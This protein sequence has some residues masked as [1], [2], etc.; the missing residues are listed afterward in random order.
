M[1]SQE[2]AGFLFD[3]DGKDRV[4]GGGRVGP[5]DQVSLLAVPYPS[6]TQAASATG[7]V[8]PEIDGISAP[9]AEARKA[10]AAEV[11]IAAAV[12]AV[13]DAIGPAAE[14][15]PS[16]DSWL[17]LAGISA[18]AA[19]AL[20]AGAQSADEILFIDGSIKGYELLIAGARP[21]VHVIVLDPTLD[22]FEQITAA[23]AGREDVAAIHL[24]SHG[25]PGRVALGNTA[26]TVQSLAQHGAQLAAWSESLSPGADFLIYGCDVGQAIQGETLLNALSA[27]TGADTAASSNLTGSGPLGSDWNLEVSHGTIT[28]LLFADPAVLAGFTS[29]LAKPVVDLNGPAILNLADNFSTNSYTGG[30]SNLATIWTSGWFEFDG[31]PTRAFNPGGSTNSDNSPVSGNVVIPNVASGGTVGGLGTGQEIAFVGHA[32][33]YGDS[34]E[35]EVN[36]KA[37]TSAILSFSYRTAGL[38]AGDV[39]EVDVSNNAGASFVTVGTL[40][41]VTTNTTATFDI[42]SYISDTTTIRFAVSSGFAAASS[43]RFYFDNVSITADGNN[44]VTNY[45]EQAATPVS[46]TGGAAVITDTDTGQLLRSATVTLA[47]LQPGDTFAVG[48][49]P[50]GIVADTGTPGT[51]ILSSATGDTAAHFMTALGAITF[52]NGSNIPDTTLRSINITVTDAGNETSLS[53]TAFVR[54]LPYDNP[55][56][57]VAH[58][59]AASSLGTTAG[60]LFDG[61]SLATQR[62]VSTTLDY[63]QDT[64]GLSAALLT[65][66]AKGAAVINPDGSYSYT[67]NAGATGADSFSYTLISQA[68]V[69]GTNYQYWN[70][71]TITSL[72]TG[73]PTSAPDKSSFIV[74]YDVD[75]VALD[76]VGGTATANTSLDNFVVRF[77]NTLTI[78]TGGS[79]TFTTGS[80]DG[81]MVYIDTAGNGTY[82]TVVDNDGLHSYLS[83]SGSIT[84]APGTYTVRVDFMERGGQEDLRVYYA[85]ADTGG[86]L[87]NL[88]DVGQVLANSTTVGTVDVDIQ[89]GGPQLAL[90]T[91]VYAL[92]NFSTQAYTNNDGT[93][94]FAG[95]WIEQIDGG[96]P[97]SGG[98]RVTGGALRVSDTSSGGSTRSIWRDFEI[99]APG[100]NASKFGYQLSFDYNTPGTSTPGVHVQISTDGGA[101]Y[102][103]LDTISANGSTGTTHKTYDISSYAGGNVRIQF[104]PASPSSTERIN[105]DNVQIDAH[106][107]NYAAGTYIENATP[108]VAIAST[109][110]IVFG[111]TVTNV[112]GATVTIANAQAGDT[113]SYDNFVAG[114]SAALNGNTLTLSGTA[115]R[116]DYATALQHVFFSSGSEDPSTAGRTINVAVTD[117][118]TLVSNTATATL[119]VTAVNDAP[120]GIDGSVSTAQNVN[121]VL[122]TTDFAYA[123]AEGNSLSALRIAT[124]PAPALGTLEYDTTGGG[125]WTTVTAN[126][127]ITAANIAAGRLRYNPATTATGNATFAFQVLDNGGTANGGVD[128]DPVANNF[129][130]NVLPGVNSR[131]MLSGNLALISSQ[132]DSTSPTPQTLSQLAAGIFADS[133]PGAYMTGLAIVGNSA[134]AGTQGAWQYSVDGATWSAVGTVGNTAGTALAL[135]A[136]TLVRFVAVADYNGVPTA[137]SV[138]A[139]DDTYGGNF[140]TSATRV[141]VGTTP[142]ASTAISSAQYSLGTAVS[143]VNDAPLLTAA[144]PTL[145][146]ISASQP[147]AGPAGQLISAF[148]GSGANHSV[149]TDVDASPL[150]GIAVIGAGGAG[151]SWQYSTDGG[152]TWNAVGAVSVN[153]GLLLDTANMIRFNPDGNS[154]GSGVLSYRA[155]DETSGSVGAKLDTSTFGGSSAFSI[156][157]DSASITVTAP[158]GPILSGASAPLSYIEQAA[159]GAIDSAI[160]VADGR[161]ANLTGATVSI[162]NYVSGQDTLSFA[163]QNGITGSWNAGTGTLTLTGT[164]TLANYQTALRSITYSNASDAPDSNSR[165][166]NYQVSDATGPSNILSTSVNVSPVNDAPALGGS[167]AVLAYV[168]NQ[169]AT[170]IDSS[171]TLTDADSPANFNAGF[172]QIALSAGAAEDQLSILATGTGPTQIATSGANVSYGG[173]TIGTINATLNGVNGQGLRIELNFNSTAEAVQALAHSIGYANSSDSP[174]TATRSVTFTLDDGGNLGSGGARSGAKLTDTISVSSV[175]EQAAISAVAENAGGGINAAEAASGSGTAVTV[176]LPAD[177]IAGDT[178]NVIWGTQPAIAYTILAADISNGYANV[179]V[180]TA[181]ITAV[182]GAINVSASVTHLPQTG[183][184]SLAFPVTVDTV[185]PAV[186]AVAVQDEGGPVVNYATHDTSPVLNG[187]A[188]P[189]STVSVYDGANLLGT[190]MADGITGAWSWSVAPAAALTAG[191]PHRFTATAT[192]LAGNSTTSSAF[193]LAINVSLAN[194]ASNLLKIPGEAQGDNSGFAL[195]GAGDVNGDGYSDIIVGAQFSSSN[196]SYSGTSYVVYGKA[197]PFDNSEL[198]LLSLNGSNGFR[199]F[200]VAAD[201]SSGFSAAGAGDVN[202]DGFGDVIVGAIYSSPNG[203]HSGAAYVVFGN[204]SAADLQLSALT[205]ANGLRLDGAAANDMAGISVSGAGDVNGDGY[206]DVLVGSYHQPA[207][208]AYLVY[209]KASGFAP[210]IALSALDGFNGFRID[211]V[212]AHD[213]AGQRVA[214]AG[215]ING[216]GYADFII[217]APGDW[218]EAAQVTADY[219]VFGKP[220][221]GAATLSLSMLDGSNGFKI[222]ALASANGTGFGIGSA[223]DV[224]GDGFGDLIVGAYNAGGSGES[225]VIFGKAGGFAAAFDL[226]ALTGTNGFRISGATADSQ[227]GYSVGAAGDINGD[228]YGDLIVGAPGVYGSTSWTG[229]SYVIYGKAAG[230]SA[231]VDLATLGGADGYRVSGVTNGEASGYNVSAAGDVNGDGFADIAVSS[232]RTTPSYNGL[233]GA[234]ETYVIFGGTEARAGAFL[235]GSG[236]DTLTGTT[237]GESFVGG[238]GNDLMLGNGGKDAFSG[239]AGDD[240][241]HLGAS[242]LSAVD[243]SRIDGGSGYDTLVLEGSAVTIDLTVPG[244][245][246]KIHGI[247][248]IDL[249]GS[250]DNTLALDIRDLLNLSDTGNQLFVTGNA[251]DSVNSAGPGWSMTASNVVDHG[252]TYDSYTVSGLTANLLVDHALLLAGGV[253]LG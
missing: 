108:G 25:D 48:A 135:S 188:E 67:P 115:T 101:N 32:N 215:D 128:T 23:L 143:P 243:F 89:S 30:S 15:S 111:P 253:H 144:T 204:A 87:T 237:A 191:I 100:S 43:Q 239:G 149:V 213:N 47:N 238:L 77:T 208:A 60:M 185:A 92:D 113:L 192:D 93:V 64:A 242:A 142:F 179:L 31:S 35:R 95:N 178:V 251:G 147:A 221:D 39:I 229:E 27:L 181:T 119:A 124:V 58:S 146:T 174:S 214:A 193:D 22:G 168:E 209:G 175:P 223:G 157:S 76:T 107:V 9:A 26:M 12:G 161:S 252:I 131:P 197:T 148:V 28:T 138:R 10:N 106:Q 226:G 11:Q 1:S 38:G 240:T 122:R 129:T 216:D 55:V 162:A 116:A 2:S 173:V 164:T 80:D 98:I 125:N 44:Y 217:G 72:K 165:T 182:Q 103:T 134:N 24:V 85:G 169:A 16:K 153:S 40:A 52:A 42:S 34:I 17:A 212:S 136:S 184:A 71:S 117:A 218:R 224:N 152:T 97:T 133:D 145:A 14:L 70:N 235:G 126:Q 202:G 241:V 231:N 160:A 250:G 166:V 207:G 140:S 172:L 199:L 220:A 246:G 4:D 236:D 137:L 210:N 18:P 49:L 75:G 141:F 45:S 59:I 150:K 73:F 186:S 78:T 7:V 46:V 219:V 8:T 19:S 183:L 20:P 156:A 79:Y 127:T 249:T 170:S 62:T 63:D 36:L 110:A 81:S 244:T 123:D 88:S 29:I 86:L 234:G 102:T 66:A 84:L 198:P 104:L 33:Q 105:F 112:S 180:P 83:A 130:V 151:G 41:N 94:S 21:G 196:G 51:V 139:L 222:S 248:R 3:F 54:V 69:I 37:Y 65:Q 91:D 177:A 245:A 176:A 206:A 13:V 205:G 158:T 118:N 228:G 227:A 187:T 132:E 56:T 233:A 190:T 200:G 230:F 201:D 82:T 232:A 99:S 163:N 155:W 121:F 6:A 211:G 74:G 114:I 61:S 50:A 109:G 5:A 53:S 90:G 203:M 194:S 171:L 225:Y 247:E 189:G 195:R 68:Q 57:A 96:S 154:A 167:P 159:A 120:L